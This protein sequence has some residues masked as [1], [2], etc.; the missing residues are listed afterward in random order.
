[1]PSSHLS[2]AGGSARRSRST[3][4]GESGS[5]RTE[6]ALGSPP[7]ECSSPVAV[8]TTH[9]SS[10][11]PRATAK[12]PSPPTRWA[13]S[14]S[15]WR[16]ASRCRMG[17]S[18]RVRISSQPSAAPQVR[19]LSRCSSRTG[20]GSRRRADSSIRASHGGASE[21]GSS[22]RLPSARSQ[23]QTSVRAAARK[24]PSGE[25]AMVRMPWTSASKRWRSAPE[26][27]SKTS[28]SPS[29]PA[30][31]TSEPSGENRS[32]V[33]SPPGKCSSRTSAREGVVR[34]VW[35]TAG[36][37]KTA[38]SNESAAVGRRWRGVDIG[39]AGLNV[40]GVRPAGGPR[41]SPA[42]RVRRR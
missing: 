39:A 7:T 41:R 1:M 42:A 32:S 17:S 31:A 19:P 29:S 20:S 2:K 11:Q 4:S 8:A 40:R 16:C 15:L 37:T 18:S 22:S 33:L 13:M 21:S 26:A 27:A 12:R 5:S 23:R 36:A 9:S 35:A 24:R 38:P 3:S 30:D 25:N 10:R 28:T 6:A 14:R 34:G